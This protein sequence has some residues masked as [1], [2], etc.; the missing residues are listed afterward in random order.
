MKK[1]SY[2]KIDKLKKLIIK[3]WEHSIVTLPDDD[4]LILDPLVIQ[5]FYTLNEIT[6]EFYDLTAEEMK[7]FNE[8]YKAY[9][10]LINDTK[11]DLLLST[12]NNKTRRRLYQKNVLDR[13]TKILPDVNI[14]T[15]PDN[16][17]RIKKLL[18]DFKDNTKNDN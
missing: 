9:K 15:L 16:A 4:R 5:D 14:Q 13:S 7:F 3:A 1:S 6:T 17:K 2:E 12:R 11:Y 18:S 10:Q 8:I